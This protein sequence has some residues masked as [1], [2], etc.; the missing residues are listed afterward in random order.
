MVQ[1]TLK[2]T[3]PTREFGLLTPDDGSRVIFVR[4]SPAIASSCTSDERGGFVIKDV[5]APTPPIHKVASS[6]EIP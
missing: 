6:V 4:F 5:V 1:G 2:W 3:S